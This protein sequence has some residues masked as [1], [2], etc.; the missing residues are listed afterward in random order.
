MVLFGPLQGAKHLNIVKQ[1]A[2][3]KPEAPATQAAGQNSPTSSSAAPS[4]PLRNPDHS[5]CI[6]GRGKQDAQSRQRQQTQ[7]AQQRQPQPTDSKCTISDGNL[8]R[9]GRPAQAVSNP[10]EEEVAAA[11]L[12]DV[13]ASLEAQA[14][15]AAQAA[16]P[17]TSKPTSRVG[18][19]AKVN[20]LHDNRQQMEANAA[21]DARLLK[22]RR[23]LCVGEHE[24]KTQAAMRP[25]KRS[26][27]QLPGRKQQQEK[28]VEEVRSD[29]LEPAPGQTGQRQAAEQPAGPSLL[30]DHAGVSHQLQAGLGQTSLG[31]CQATPS[32]VALRMML[33]SATPQPPAPPQPH[34]PPRQQQQQETGDVLG[35]GSATGAPSAMAAGAGGGASAYPAAGAMR[36]EPTGSDKSSAGRQVAAAR[37]RAFFSAE[38]A[39][40]RL[41][42]PTAMAATVLGVL[43]TAEMPEALQQAQ[44]QRLLL[45]EAGNRGQAQV[46]AETEAH[47]GAQLSAGLKRLLRDVLA[48]AA[49]HCIQPVT[50]WLVYQGVRRFM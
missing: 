33:A 43:P 4:P 42:E 7:Q 32:S 22:R 29:S 9:S 46:V 8:Q 48:E 31:T 16:Q 18:E 21:R 14:V 20:T 25:S 3:S 27:Q 38:H 10:G 45:P 17:R 6:A 41:D 47:E 26:K 23:H 1:D 35:T 40:G 36:G 12:L 5:P 30:G 49:P 2:R 24:G 34:P 13:A 39:E 44:R 15:P 37:V 19:E 50:D 11:A 28:R